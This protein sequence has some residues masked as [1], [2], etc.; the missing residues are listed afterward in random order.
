MPAAVE[1]EGESAIMINTARNWEMILFIVTSRPLA[2]KP[3]VAIRPDCTDQERPCSDS[4]YF[5]RS[6]IGTPCRECTSAIFLRNIYVQVSRLVS[7]NLEQRVRKSRHDPQRR[8]PGV[9]IGN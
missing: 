8:T 2:A 5:A 9:S 6:N 4:R 1:S 7:W 3:G